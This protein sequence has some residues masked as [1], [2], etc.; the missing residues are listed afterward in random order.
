MKKILAILIILGLAGV[1][2]W[3]GYKYAYKKPV[4]LPTTS[5]TTGA[6]T[7][8]TENLEA[9]LQQTEDDGGA[10]DFVELEKSAEGL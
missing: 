4:S 9:E 7:T 10:A 1:L 2:V 3:A 8:K 5:T 6:S